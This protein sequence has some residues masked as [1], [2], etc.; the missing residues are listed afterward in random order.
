MAEA[1]RYP[2]LFAQR[3]VLPVAIACGLVGVVLGQALW[4]R[5]AFGAMVVGMGAVALVLRRARPEVL[6]DDQG[7]AVREFGKEKLRVGWSEVVKVR[8]D[9]AEKAAYVD[10][11]D[12]SRNLLV[13]PARG[14]GFRFGRA[15]ELYARILAAV[16][17]SLIERV[18]RLDPQ[19]VKKG[20]S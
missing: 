4:M 5:L 20:K 13:P 12:P 17:A 14:Y 1:A 6:I 2:I 7:Y 18:E 16:P 11:G 9:E 15:D 19:P 3:R 10:C 8:A